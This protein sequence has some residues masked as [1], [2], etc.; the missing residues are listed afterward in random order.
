MQNYLRYANAIL[1]GTTE[2]TTNAA[3]AS[4][5]LP[6]KHRLLNDP[7][8]GGTILVSHPALDPAAQGYT[9]STTSRAWCGNAVV[10][11]DPD[12]GTFFR[13][14]PPARLGVPNRI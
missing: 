1:N 14:R 11:R 13:T 3:A 10:V 12:T 8:P 2:S 6:P 9:Q 4:L 7:G 5:L